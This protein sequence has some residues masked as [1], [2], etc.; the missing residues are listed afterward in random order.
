MSDVKQITEHNEE[1]IPPQYRKAPKP[2]FLG[3]LW[4]VFDAPKEEQRVLWKLDAV[5]ITFMSLGYFLKN[6]GES[7]CPFAAGEQSAD[8]ESSPQIKPTSARRS[9]PGT[10]KMFGYNMGLFSRSC[11]LFTGT[12]RPKRWRVHPPH[13]YS[14]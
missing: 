3:S 7:F 8:L 13:P 11:R 14:C 5:L 10:L 9:S 6:L 1:D 2:S 12:W 4:D